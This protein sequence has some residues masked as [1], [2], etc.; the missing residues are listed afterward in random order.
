MQFSLIKPPP[1]QLYDN[2]FA[3]ITLINDFAIVPGYVLVMK[4]FKG[5]KFWLKYDRG[6]TYQN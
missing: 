3:Y 5:T 6:K 4:Q 2:K 1:F